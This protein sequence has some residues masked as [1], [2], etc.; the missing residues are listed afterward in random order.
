M[1]FDKLRPNRV[2]KPNIFLASVVLALASC[3]GP[4]SQLAS[5]LQRAGLGKA[6]SACMAERMVERLSVG[7]LLKLRSLGS[8]GEDRPQTAREFVRRV[9]ALGD[10]EI[11]SVTTA[12]LAMCGLGL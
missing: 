8:L 3:A 5:G 7:Q 4:E 10:P 9:R 12:S 6:T 1:A 11:V 2:D